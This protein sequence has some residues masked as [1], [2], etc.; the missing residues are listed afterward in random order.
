MQISVS[1]KFQLKITIFAQKGYFQSKTEKS[2]FCVRPWSLLTI[3]KLIV[4]TY[5]VKIFLMGA[6]RRNYTFMPLLL[7]ASDNETLNSGM[8][9]E[10]HRSIPVYHIIKYSCNKV[11]LIS[12]LVKSRVLIC[13]P[14][15]VG[16][17][18]TIS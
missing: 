6:D 4:V 5:Y 17:G 14:R 11:S 12:L 15:K 8:F 7:L 13:M 3:L 16:T 1:T 9:K 2:Y 10:S 18:V